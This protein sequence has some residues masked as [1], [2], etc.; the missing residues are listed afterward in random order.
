MSNED[1]F[2]VGCLAVLFIIL[3]GSLLLGGIRGCS[4]GTEVTIPNRMASQKSP[5]RMHFS[6]AL[7]GGGI[8]AGVGI[9]AL[10]R[11][12]KNND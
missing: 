4:A 2:N 6:F 7:I 1:R 12:F 5:Y 10:Y 11:I 9:F 3:G 8:F